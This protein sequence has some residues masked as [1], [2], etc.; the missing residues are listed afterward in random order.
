[1]PEEVPAA[2]PATEALE[3]EVL[4]T[5]VPLSRSVIWRLQ[6]DY[7]AQRGLAA[8]TEDMV[9]SYITNNPLIAEIHAGIVA[10]YMEDCLRQGPAPS[11]ENPLRILELGAGTGKFCY[12]FLRKLTGLL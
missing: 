1:M 8:W 7:Y 11:Q 5:A 10:A 4:E 3:T 9:P 2:Q 12:L 6:R